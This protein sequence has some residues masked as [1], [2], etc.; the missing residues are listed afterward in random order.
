MPR[1]GA[2]DGGAA[3]PPG[4][5]RGQGP[6]HE[7][8]RAAER[9]VG[10]HESPEERADRRWGE[11]LQE[12]RVAQTGVQILFGFLMTVVFTPKFFD[13]PTTDRNIYVVTVVLGAATMGALIGPVSFHRL[14]TGHRLKPETVT[15]ASRLTIVGVVL[16]LATIVSALLLILRIALRN[17]AVPW[18]VAG[19]SVWFVLCWFGLPAWARHRYARRERR[20]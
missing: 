8:E 7:G 3:D 19:L 15:W 4:G 6:E 9:R 17:S 5:R 11:L 14:V 1:N 16:L 12:V 10:R 2:H 18:L 13:L 20:E